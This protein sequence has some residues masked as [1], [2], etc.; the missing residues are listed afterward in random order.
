VVAL[1]IE[2]PAW[3]Q[4]RVSEALKGRGLDEFAG[5]RALYLASPRPDLD[6]TAPEGA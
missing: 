6:E 1:A 3:D 2:Q 5:G 4:V